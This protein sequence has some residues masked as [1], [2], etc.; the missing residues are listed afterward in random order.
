MIEKYKISDMI[1]L[2][3]TNTQLNIIYSL[4]RKVS[5]GNGNGEKLTLLSMLRFCVKKNV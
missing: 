2:S 1:D 3:F 5:E 4:R